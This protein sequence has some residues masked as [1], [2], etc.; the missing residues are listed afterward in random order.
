[1]VKAAL[2]VSVPRAFEGGVIEDAFHGTDAVAAR[3]IMESGFR[4]GSGLGMYGPGVY[5]FEGDYNAA[6]MWAR[7]HAKAPSPVVLRS[8]LAL[9][10]TLYLN[11]LGP[12]LQ[13]FKERLQQRLARPVKDSQAYAVLRAQLARCNVVDSIKA[14]RA[15]S[16]RERPKR[17]SKTPGMRAEVVVVPLD[18]AR[19]SPLEALEPGELSS[20]TPLALWE[21]QSNGT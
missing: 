15:I 6:F 16:R 21:N 3:S 1:M 2:T 9:G 8:R 12:E 5:F 20:S 4:Q 19:A 14:V 18:P 10:R 17:Q 13:R 11:L 7:D